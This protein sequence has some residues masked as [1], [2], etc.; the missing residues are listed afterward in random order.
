[1]TTLATARSAIG[2]R[3]A[4]QAGVQAIYFLRLLVLARLLA[5]EAFGQLAIATLIISTLL[6]LSDLGVVPALV[7]RQQITRDD[8]DAAW[9]LGL[10]RASIVAG[11]VVLTAPLLA[12][13]FGDPTTTILIQALALRPVLTALGSIGIVRL[14]RGFRFR[15]LAMIEIPAAVLDTCVAIALAATLGVWALVIGALVGS[16]GGAIL[17]HVLAPHRPRLVLRATTMAPLIQFGRWVL[18]TSVIGLIASGGVQFFISRG[19]GVTEL[20]LYFLAAKIAFLPADAASTVLGAATFPVYAGLQR[21]DA[22]TGEVL[23]AL[24]IG[25][26]FVLFPVYSLMIALAPSL[27]E[28]LGP[29]WTGTAPL[30]QAIGLAAM[31]GLYADATLPLL[32]GRGR[33]DRSMLVVAA[34]T[35]VLLLLV[36]PFMSAW[37]VLGAAAAW[38]PAYIAALAVSA[39][40]VRRM[41]G[42]SLAG[43]GPQLLALLAV[44]IPAAAAAASVRLWMTGVPALAAGLL[45]GLGTGA[46]LLIPLRR[47]IERGLGVWLRPAFTETAA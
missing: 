23:R 38:V 44:A 12:V 7:Q 39:V 32:S 9:T 6:S 35:A 37:G 15:R 33:P 16:A 11:V 5:P 13:L 45:L 31:L 8:E 28:A 24:L 2:W 29:R 20:G 46:L 41:I 26:A 14:T 42:R 4:Q 18:G 30:I 34:Q 27:A 3:A 17:S 22:R 47:Q 36:L 21:D 10:L 19:L 43:A 25:L 40:F 1:M